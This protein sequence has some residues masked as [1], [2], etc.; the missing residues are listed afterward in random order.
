MELVGI[1]QVQATLAPFVEALAAIEI[2]DPE[3]LVA[4]ALIDVLVPIRIAVGQAARLG[5]L[6]VI[7]IL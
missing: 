1:G 2:L 4:A 3:D 6:L 7:R 5:V